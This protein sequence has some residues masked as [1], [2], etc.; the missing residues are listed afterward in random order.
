MKSERRRL[1]VFLEIAPNG[2]DIDISHL[3]ERLFG[4]SICAIRTQ[5]VQKSWKP[6]RQ[7]IR[8]LLRLTSFATSQTG[9][10]GFLTGFIEQNVINFG[11]FGFA[12]W[13]AIDSCGPDANVEF[14]IVMFVIVD[15]S[16]Q[17]FF[18]R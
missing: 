13:K 7:N 15:E 1:Q 14:S 5:V 18:A 2:R 17:H 9:G 6:I 10:D 3:S 16:L 11:Q 8:I 4:D 12:G